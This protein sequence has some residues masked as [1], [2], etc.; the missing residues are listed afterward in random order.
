M[1][2][3]FASVL[4][5]ATLASEDVVIEADGSVAL[6]L[7]FKIDAQGDEP[8]TVL[9]L[10]APES[11]LPLLDVI[12][13]RRGVPI[14]GAIFKGQF[15]LIW[16]T[17]CRPDQC[18]F[19]HVILIRIADRNGVCFEKKIVPTDDELLSGVVRDWGSITLRC[20]E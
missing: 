1:T 12:N 11:D 14:E 5:L 13:G 8:L 2:I 4:I 9:A 16:G 10:S 7:T 15:E 20:Q 17:R 19:R 6:H 3:F 18:A